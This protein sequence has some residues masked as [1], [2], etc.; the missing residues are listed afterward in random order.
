MTLNIN[1]N[2]HLPRR[3]VV[4]LA[5]IAAVATFLPGM[6]N[7]KCADVTGKGDINIVAAAMPAV[8]AFVKEMETCS[9]AGV[10]VAVKLTPEA[11]TEKRRDGDGDCQG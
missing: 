3:N 8:Q 1:L 9:R 7:A 2:A 6:A 11:R 10:T 5:T 4:A